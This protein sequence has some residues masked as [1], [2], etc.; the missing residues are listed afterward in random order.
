ML[1]RKKLIEMKNR[2]TWPENEGG[3]TRQGE[4]P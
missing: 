2:K 1:H 4:G 3:E